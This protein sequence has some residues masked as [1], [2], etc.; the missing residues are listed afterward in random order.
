ME[1]VTIISLYNMNDYYDVSIKE[2]RLT[3]KEKEVAKHPSSR[4]VFV[5]GNIVAKAHMAEL[6]EKYHF[7][8]VMNLAV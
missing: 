3:E 4:W 6:F 8:V 7:S 5:L 2:Y 1:T